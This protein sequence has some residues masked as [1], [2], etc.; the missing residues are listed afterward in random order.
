[1][2]NSLLLLIRRGTNHSNLSAE[3]LS[4]FDGNVAKPT[5]ANHADVHSRLVKSKV[6]QGAV[7]CD[8][9]AQQGSPSM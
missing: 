8:T 6:S 9:S 4:K 3:G 7:N 2:F 1:M 5:E